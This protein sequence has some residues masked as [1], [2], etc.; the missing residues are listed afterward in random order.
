MPALLCGPWTLKSGTEPSTEVEDEG[1]SDTCACSLIVLP[2]HR[3]KLGGVA[4]GNT[5]LG[6]KRTT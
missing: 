5:S 6:V 2:G 3:Q 4:R 1:P